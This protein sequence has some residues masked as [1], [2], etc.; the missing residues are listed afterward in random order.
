ME[1]SY[2][3]NMTPGVSLTSKGEADQRYRSIHDVDTDIIIVG[4]GIYRSDDPVDSVKK[5]CAFKKPI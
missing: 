4:R 2:L 5:Y 1:L 3:W